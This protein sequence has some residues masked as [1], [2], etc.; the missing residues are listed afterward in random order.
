MPGDRARRVGEVAWLFLKLGII[1]FGGAAVHLAAA[2]RGRNII[3]VA[4]P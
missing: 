1:G 2:R 3:P 4:A